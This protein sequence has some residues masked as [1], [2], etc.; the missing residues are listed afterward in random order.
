MPSVRSKLPPRPSSVQQT[1][2]LPAG[3]A[4]S[5]TDSLTGKHPFRP[6]EDAAAMTAVNGSCS[7]T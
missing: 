3:H 1:Q 4:V 6:A 7:L 5:R 2:Q